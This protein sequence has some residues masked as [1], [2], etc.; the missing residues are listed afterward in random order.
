M[1]A[2]EDEID[3]R[4]KQGPRTWGALARRRASVAFAT[5]LVVLLIGGE[6]PAELGLDALGATPAGLALC[7]VQCEGCSGPGRL[8]MW[9][10]RGPWRSNKGT[11]G[12][13]LVCE[14]PSLTLES[15][16]WVDVSRG[17]ALQ[18]YI[19]SGFVRYL[20]NALSVAAVVG[21]FGLFGTSASLRRKAAR[22]AELTEQRRGA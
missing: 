11:M 15:M 20:F 7:P 3:R 22:R 13:A 6:I 1:S 2:S 18:P 17:D 14:H 4:V 16:T 5:A 9:R 19:L 12:S 21:L 8:F 10:Y